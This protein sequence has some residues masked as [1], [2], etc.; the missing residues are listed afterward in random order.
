MQRMRGDDAIFISFLPSCSP[1]RFIDEGGMLF[2]R[3]KKYYAFSFDSQLVG[4][5][6]DIVGKHQKCHEMNMSL[7]DH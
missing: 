7:L 1:A 2:S 6:Q 4:D 3:S 5:L